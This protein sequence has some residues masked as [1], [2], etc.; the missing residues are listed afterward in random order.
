MLLGDTN[1]CARCMKATWFDPDD[2]DMLWCSECGWELDEE[3]AIAAAEQSEQSDREK[4][5][6][7]KAQEDRLQF[8]L[9]RS[10]CSR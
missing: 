8:F 4:L 7:K 1:F 9:D 3:K 10:N 5:E 6:E 2:R